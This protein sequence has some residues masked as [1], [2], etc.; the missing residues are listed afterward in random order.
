MRVLVLCDDT[1]HAGKTVREGLAPLEEAGLSFV[2]W[3]DGRGL[4][5]QGLDPYSLVIL[6]KSDQRTMEDDTPWLTGESLNALEE[7][8]KEGGGLLAVHSGTCYDGNERMERLLGGVFL[9]HPAQCP[10]T[11]TPCEEESPLMEGVPPFPITDEFYVMRLCDRTA[12]V[13]ATLE[14]AHGSQPAVWTKEYGFGRVCCVTP[15]HN[16]QSWSAPGFQ[17]LL[18]NAVQFCTKPV[19]TALVTGAGRGLGFGLTESLLRRNWQ[20]VAGEYD[21]TASFLPRLS[22]EFPQRLWVTPLDVT[23]PDSIQAAGKYTAGTVGTLDLLISNAGVYGRHEDDRYESGLHPDEML[24]DY[25]V[26]ALGPVLLLE[27]FAPRMEQSGLR[28]V[29]VVSSEAGSIGACWRDNAFGYSMSKAAVNMGTQI[30]FHCLRPKGYTFRLYH[31]G[32]LR[33]YMLGEKNL[34]AD[35]EPEEGA[36]LA[37]SYFLSD[38]QNED[39]LALYSYDGREYPW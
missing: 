32:Y 11:L 3:E 18:K 6:S 20:V 23:D 9:T 29:C 16:P 27:A 7:F 19:G 38:R 22:E 10:V 28:R 35:L 14:S 25:R 2:F 34:A 26:N 37:L 4:T 39:A 33:T 36:R 24:W 5:P 31:P 17:T 21:S 13:H 12:T 8:V 30:W 15:A 1:Y